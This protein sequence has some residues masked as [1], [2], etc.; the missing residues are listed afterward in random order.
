MKLGPRQGLELH[1][2]FQSLFGRTKA[3]IL[4]VPVRFQLAVVVAVLS[5]GSLQNVI[6]LYLFEK[7]RLLS[8]FL[9]KSLVSI[10]FVFSEFSRFSVK[11]NKC[12][13]QSE[14]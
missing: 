1:C 5:I 10:Y 12:S 14:V 8:L 2:N 11:I 13:E 4:S 3:E 6:S 9:S 7:I